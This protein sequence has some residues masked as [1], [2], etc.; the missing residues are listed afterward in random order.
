MFWIDVPQA[1]E[2]LRRCCDA[3]DHPYGV[4]TPL[5]TLIK[6][7]IAGDR[8]LHL[9]PAPGKPG[10]QQ[11]T[12]GLVSILQQCPT[13]RA[14][15]VSKPSSTSSRVVSWYRVSR[16]GTSSSADGASSSAAGMLT[17][18]ATAQ[19]CASSNGAGGSD[20]MLLD[21][22]AGDD[23]DNDPMRRL[24]LANG[25]AGASARTSSIDGSHQHKQPQQ[26]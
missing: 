22:D 7:L 14:A 2:Y 26:Q 1:E 17:M 23:S 13:A 24:L 21:I 25:S 6:P 15:Q 4:H 12:L 8:F 19:S 18:P 11:I 5:W 16:T 10:N 3:G 20:D 9:G